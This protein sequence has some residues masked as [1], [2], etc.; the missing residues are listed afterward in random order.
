MNYH[1][2]NQRLGYSCSNA[3]PTGEPDYSVLITRRPAGGGMIYELLKELQRRVALLRCG[4]SFHYLPQ[5]LAATGHTQTTGSGDVGTTDRGN[6]PFLKC[7]Q[8]RKQCERC[9][10]FQAYRKAICTEQNRASDLDMRG[11]TAHL[12]SSGSN[13]QRESTQVANF[14]G[15]VGSPISAK[16]GSWDHLQS[17]AIGHPALPGIDHPECSTQDGQAE[18]HPLTQFCATHTD[19][20]VFDSSNVAQEGGA[21]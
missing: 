14:Y 2:K 16:R 18:G 5:D 19:L 21:P 20:P 4:G 7:S 9:P 8:G 15:D 6:L 11:S 12:K 13:S 17:N 1:L 3:L 10:R